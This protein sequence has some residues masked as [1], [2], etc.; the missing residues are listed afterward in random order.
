MGKKSVKTI[1]IPAPILPDLTVH[2][3]VKSKPTCHINNIYFLIILFLN[4]F[5]TSQ[6]SEAGG[7]YLRE[8]VRRTMQQLLTHNVELHL[9]WS[10][11]SGPKAKEDQTE[12]KAFRSFRSCQAVRGKQAIPTSKFK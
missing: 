10:G 6:L 2:A 5:Q 9:N 8:A 1:G 7:V 4:D 3:R 11:V 12:R